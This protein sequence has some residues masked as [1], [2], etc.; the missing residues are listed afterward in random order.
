MRSATIDQT[1]TAG[2]LEAG[3]LQEGQARAQIAQELREGELSGC[4]HQ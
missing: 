1:V 3:H 2:E 4:E